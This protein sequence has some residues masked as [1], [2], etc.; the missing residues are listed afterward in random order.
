[1]STHCELCLLTT[2]CAGRSVTA[3]KTLMTTES[4][5]MSRAVADY[6]AAMNTRR[7]AAK[8][9][10]EARRKAFALARNYLWQARCN[11]E[12]LCKKAA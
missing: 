1:M 10:G 6:S 8:L 11:I 7:D 2:P 9:S 5:L 12:N 3:M 4:K